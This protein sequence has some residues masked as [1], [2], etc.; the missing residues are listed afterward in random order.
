M[1]LL[2]EVIGYVLTF[3]GVAV[4]VVAFGVLSVVALFK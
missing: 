1:E 2:Q 3:F 4:L